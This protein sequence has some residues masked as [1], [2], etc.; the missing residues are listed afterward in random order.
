LPKKQGR[1]A[2]IAIKP[3]NV[4][5]QTL[6]PIQLFI[7]ASCVG[8]KSPLVIEER[9]VTFIITGLTVEIHS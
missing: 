4:S 7:D 3:N 5:I 8:M 9:S 2:A 6:K 1:L